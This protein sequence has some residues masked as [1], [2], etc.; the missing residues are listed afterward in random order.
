MRLHTLLLVTVAAVVLA[1][2]GSEKA[3]TTA[4]GEQP[5]VDATS[6]A[7]VV[8][9]AD[10]V[11]AAAAENGTWI[12]AITRDVTV[13][14]EIVLAGEF[15]NRDEVARKIALYAQDDNRAITDRYTLTAPRL[16]VRSPN[17]RIQGGT[18]VGDVR[19]EANGFLIVDATVD[20][21]VT[22][23]SDEYR[24]SA[25]FDEGSVLGEIAVE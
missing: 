10:G 13:D 5:A 11:L 7:S 20:G 22:F 4:A 3:D 6:T 1:A 8:D 24:Q 9:T 17:A 14:E 23:A 12:V 2:C 16:I 18:F 25:E 15:T 19:V 21:D